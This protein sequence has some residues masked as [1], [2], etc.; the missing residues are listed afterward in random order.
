MHFSKLMKKLTG[1]NDEL[2]ATTQVIVKES[3]PPAPAEAPP[4]SDENWWEL[5][6]F[7]THR[8]RLGED[9][10][11]TPAGAVADTDW[12]T[13]LVV[14][15][16]NGSL[17]GKTLVDLGCLEGGFSLA[18]AKLGAQRALGIEARDISVRRCKVAQQLLSLSNVEFVCGDI[19]D[20]L[21]KSPSA[22]DVV[23]AAGILYHVA[24]PYELLRSM[25]DACRGFTVV[26]THVARA[27]APSH[28]CLE[29][30]T[31][32]WEGHTYQG[33]EFI[34]FPSNVEFDSREKF[35]WAAWSD[36]RSFWPLE[37]DLVRMMRDVGFRNIQ[38]SNP[39][40]ANVGRWGVDQTNRVIYVA[41]K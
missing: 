2:S 32:S 23:F 12:R 29:I 21:L 20:E 24:N 1:G 31:R 33:R 25:Y 19:K 14:N 40:S 26:D 39:D 27:D 8:I 35:L 15:C 38:K 34:E 16:C 13:S 17:A 41:Q 6:P 3:I 22:F 10:W 28:G 37:E 11:T 18:F 30:T 4:Q 9:L 36:Q 7:T 5:F